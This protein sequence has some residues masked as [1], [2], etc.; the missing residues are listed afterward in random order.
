MFSYYNLLS[1]LI[2]VESGVG[3]GFLTTANTSPHNIINYS[4]FKLPDFCSVFQADITAIRE[5]T[6]VYGRWDGKRWDGGDGRTKDGT[7]KDGRTKDAGTK[8]ARTKDART[9]NSG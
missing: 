3:A 8:D 1:L 9:A 2:K 7:T 5:D 6:T 4:Y